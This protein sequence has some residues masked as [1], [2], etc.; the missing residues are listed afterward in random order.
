MKAYILTIHMIDSDPVVWRRVIMPAGATF[1]RLHDV[2]QNATNFQSGYPHEAY[3]LY[4]FDLPE[5]NQQVTN[6]EEAYFAHQHYKKHPSVYQERLQRLDGQSLHYEKRRQERLKVEVRKPSGLKIDRYLEKYKKIA[7]QYDFGEDW[8]FSVTLEAVVEDY[9]FG[10]AQLIAGEGT[11]PPEDVGGWAGFYEFLEVYRQPNH[12]DYEE[13]KAWAASQ[14]FHW[15]NP[16]RINKRLKS[17][18]YQKTEWN[19]I[20]HTNY[21]IIKDKYFFN[22]D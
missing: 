12:V 2:I 6:D 7:Y 10:F 16:A 17:V 20:D 15:Y 1:R 11:S 18:H 19:N 9:P 8:T 4:C 22:H 14:E 3:H 13:L 21:A 5:D